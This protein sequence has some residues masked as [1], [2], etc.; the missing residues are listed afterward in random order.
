[1]D[2][3]VL[4]IAIKARVVDWVSSS[5][6][7]KFLKICVLSLLLHPPSWIISTVIMYSNKLVLVLAVLKS[8]LALIPPSDS[9]LLHPRPTNVFIPAPHESHHTLNGWLEKLPWILRIEGDLSLEFTAYGENLDRSLDDEVREALDWMIMDIST[10]GS[11]T[12]FSQP[13]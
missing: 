8:S 2:I 11:P 12:E 13:F 7:A 3:P 6:R 1:M 4:P 9:I 5:I 10:E